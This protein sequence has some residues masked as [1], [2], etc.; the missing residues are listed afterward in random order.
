MVA[1]E[2]H[3]QHRQHVLFK[4]F[5]IAPKVSGRRSVITSPNTVVSLNRM[6]SFS[7]PLLFLFLLFSLFSENSD[8]FLY[9]HE[10]LFHAKKKP[11]RKESIEHR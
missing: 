5:T 7:F 6:F 3:G 4:I 9:A 8:T 2:P 10:I 1:M 11:S